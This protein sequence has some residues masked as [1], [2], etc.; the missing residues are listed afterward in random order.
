MR[1]DFHAMSQDVVETLGN[2]LSRIFKRK[3]VEV[4]TRVLLVS[5]SEIVAVETVLIPMADDEG[6]L[7]RVTM[8]GD[9]IGHEAVAQGVL[10]R[11]LGLDVEQ[12]LSPRL[13][14]RVLLVDVVRFDE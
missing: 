12:G 6:R 5:D 1:L 9:M 7:S 8:E 13:P 14:F 3:D 10:W 2:R 11:A 4:L